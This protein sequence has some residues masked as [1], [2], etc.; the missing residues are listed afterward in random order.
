MTHRRHATRPQKLE[1]ITTTFNMMPD[2]SERKR[3]RLL[4]GF[5]LAVTLC[6]HARAHIARGRVGAKVKQRGAGTGQLSGQICHYEVNK[7]HGEALRCFDQFTHTRN[8]QTMKT[9]HVTDKSAKP[10]SIKFE[11]QIKN[12]TTPTALRFYLL[13]ST[14]SIAQTQ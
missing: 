3:E 1:K 14:H 11:N 9:R 4:R 13:N 7:C 10:K 2:I 5:V 8:G 6:W 12:N